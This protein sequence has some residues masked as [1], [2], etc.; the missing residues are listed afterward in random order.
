MGRNLG[1]MSFTPFTGPTFV[2]GGPAG[3]DLSGT[4]PN[5]TVA[6]SSAATF[7]AL[8]NMNV[9]GFASISNGA[10]IFGT[11]FLYSGMDTA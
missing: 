1:I 3:G 7:T 6:Q 4:Y 9:N 2:P 10:N 11:L 8:H 5:P